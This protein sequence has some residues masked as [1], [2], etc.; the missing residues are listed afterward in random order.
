[1]I[2]DFRQFDLGTDYTKA[3]DKLMEAVGPGDFTEDSEVLLTEDQ[4]IEIRRDESAVRRYSAAYRS[5]GLT[6]TN[7]AGYKIKFV[8][9]S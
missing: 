7:A 1:M 9:K 2:H 6:L 5:P 8:V 4:E 3:L